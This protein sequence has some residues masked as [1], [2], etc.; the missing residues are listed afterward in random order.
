MIYLALALIALNLADILLTVSVLSIGG[1]EGNPLVR[2]L[3][4][5]VGVVGAAVIK[6]FVVGMAAYLFV[7]LKQRFW[8]IASVV[9]MG[10]VVLWNIWILLLL[11][12]N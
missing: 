11:S 2:Y 5:E 3:L 10:G 9:G 1:V 8:L 12:T 7:K 6:M 4:A